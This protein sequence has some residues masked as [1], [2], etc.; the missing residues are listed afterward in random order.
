M[1]RTV[2]VPAAALVILSL[3]S[4]VW[5]QAGFS[6]FRPPRPEPSAGRD[7]LQRDVAT[8]TKIDGEPT[9]K[10]SAPKVV[11]KGRESSFD[12]SEGR[13]CGVMHLQAC[14]YVVEV[15]PL[16]Y[17]NQSKYYHFCR[18]VSPY[19]W[20]WAFGKAPV[21]R[22]GAVY[23]LKPGAHQWKLYCKAASVNSRRP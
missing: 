8:D 22:S 21:G 20:T 15:Y 10:G 13:P 19:G 7:L 2:F 9:L 6:F 12:L 4:V 14:K 23:Y 3:A 11:Y 5:A 18:E 1:R 17:L 16:R